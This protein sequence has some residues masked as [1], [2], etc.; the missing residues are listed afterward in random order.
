MIEIYLLRPDISSPTDGT[1]V[2]GSEWTGTDV[3]SVTYFK[4]IFQNRGKKVSNK[5]I[6]S[7]M[8]S[9]KNM[10]INIKKVPRVEVFSDG[11]IGNLTEEAAWRWEQAMDYAIVEWGKM[12]DKY[13]KIYRKNTVSG[14]EFTGSHIWNGTALARYQGMILDYEISEDRVNNI[15]VDN[16][17]IGWGG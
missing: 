4:F 12:A 17:V 10:Q 3:E 14:S 16:L 9:H 13:C 15:T 2:E 7:L 6:Q 1:P 8:P 5:I 11:Y